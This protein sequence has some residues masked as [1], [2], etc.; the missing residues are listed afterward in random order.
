MTELL[1][2]PRATA[3]YDDDAWSARSTWLRGAFGAAWA[4]AVGVASL[5]VVVLITWAADSRA[6][7]G[8]G[9]AVRAALQVW[10]AGHHVALHVGD[11]TI[12]IAPLLLTI[13]FAALVARAA[14]SVA[15]T[16]GVTDGFGVTRVALAVGLPYAVL[17]TFVAAAATSAPVRPSPAGALGFGLVLGCLSAA[18]GAARGVGVTAEL[19]ARVP[20]RVR[21]P[22]SAGGAA[23]LVLLAGSSLLLLASLAVHGASV[24]GAVTALGG[25]GVGATVIVVLDVALLPNAV[26][27][28]LG[29]VAG[30]GFAVGAGADV[31]LAGA[32]TGTLPALPLLEAMPNGS[33]STAVTGLAIAVVVA[34]G[35]VAAR[36]IAGAGRPLGASMVAAVGAGAAAGLLAAVLAAVAGGPAGPGRMATVGVSPWQVGLVVA[37][38]IAVV[39]AGIVGALTWRRGR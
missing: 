20:E 24:A 16:D 35:A 22:A 23:V 4:V 29:Y 27:F 39:A 38:E 10:L 36:R 19:W 25:G 3:T 2:R 33:A 12:A 21:I 30:P 9:S 17:T 8:A 14:A 31:T 18:W 34:A 28:V 32:S 7:S 1:T 37:A 13:C 26:I 11:G 15:R 5:V 6:A